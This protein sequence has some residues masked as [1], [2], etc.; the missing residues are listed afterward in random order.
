M[1]IPLG[2]AHKY[3]AE[4]WMDWYYKPEIAAQLTAYVQYVSPVKGTK[5]EI[6]KID[7]TLATDPFIF[8]DAALEAQLN[9]FAGLSE[10]DEIY[11]ND[12]FSALQGN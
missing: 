2:A 5:E 8:P 7:A 6:A 4:K 3:T 1:L 12:A 11:M 9:V 10:E